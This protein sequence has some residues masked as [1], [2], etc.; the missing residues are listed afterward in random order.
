MYIDKLFIYLQQMAL[1]SVDVGKC[2]DQRAKNS[3]RP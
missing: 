3:R 2:T 1:E